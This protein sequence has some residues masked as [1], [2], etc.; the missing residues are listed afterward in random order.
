MASTVTGIAAL[1]A[2]NIPCVQVGSVNL[3]GK[4]NN[5]DVKMNHVNFYARSTG[6]APQLWATKNVS[7]AYT[8]VPALNESITLNSPGGGSITA[9]FTPVRWDSN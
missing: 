9:S 1:E 8:A 3:E 4:G 5:L 2:L 6:D 7:G